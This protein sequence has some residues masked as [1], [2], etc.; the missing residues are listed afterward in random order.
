MS[1]DITFVDR[2]STYPNRY[3]MITDDGVSRYVVL[4][5]ADEPLNEGTPLNAETFNRML[6]TYY[7]TH[8]KP[9]P[10]EI[11]AVSDKPFE[12]TETTLAED[13]SEWALTG[14]NC[15]EIICSFDGKSRTDDDE[16]ADVRFVVNDSLTLAFGGDTSRTRASARFY[17]RGGYLFVD[18]LKDPT[19]LNDSGPVSACNAITSFKIIA[20]AS[21]LIL[22][23]SDITIWKQSM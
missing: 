2:E 4:E 19:Q 15:T 8:N 18:V 3:L 9:T 23:N 11:G 5:R 6:D 14:L 7:G 10:A 22:A 12:V 1:E 13:V 16:Y 20:P 21:C 17:V